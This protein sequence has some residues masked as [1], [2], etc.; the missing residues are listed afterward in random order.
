MSAEKETEV[1]GLSSKPVW[2]GSYGGDYRSMVADW[3]CTVLAF[4]TCGSYQGDHVVLLADGDRRGY[5]VIGYGSCSGCDSLE[6][7]SSSAP[8]DYDD[9]DD[10]DVPPFDW[11]EINQFSTDTRGTVHW[12]DSAPQ[13]AVWLQGRLEADNDWWSFDDE[14]KAVNEWFIQTLAPGAPA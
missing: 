9:E 12:E 2:W 13:L 10:E 7:M 4:E 1:S 14:V 5:L 8:W 11:T 6:A 3:G